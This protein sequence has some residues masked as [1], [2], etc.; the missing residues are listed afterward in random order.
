[1]VGHHS[2][3]ARTFLPFVTM[4]TGGV[5]LC[6]EVHYILPVSKEGRLSGEMV[7]GKRRRGLRGAEKE[8]G[9]VVMW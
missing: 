9:E 6:L 5:S 8:K 4:Q 2:W 7:K 3:E 1:M